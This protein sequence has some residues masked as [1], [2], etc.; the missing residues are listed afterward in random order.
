M[1]VNFNRFKRTTTNQIICTKLYRAA[2]SNLKLIFVVNML[3]VFV[4]IVSFQIWLITIFDEYKYWLRPNLD[5][6]D[7]AGFMNKAANDDKDKYMAFEC[8]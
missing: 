7:L 5:K 1:L 6:S 2:Q 3:F 4:L 8:M